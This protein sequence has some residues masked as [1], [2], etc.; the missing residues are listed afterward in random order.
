MYIFAAKQNMTELDPE[1]IVKIDKLVS[2]ID[3]EQDSSQNEIK[4]K[5]EEELKPW[6]E[7]YRIWREISKD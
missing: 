4:R 1:L 6:L 5:T 2:Q 7:K 3:A